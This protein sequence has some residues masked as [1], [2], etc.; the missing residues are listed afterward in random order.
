MVLPMDQ[1]QLPNRLALLIAIGGFMVASGCST[2][3]SIPEVGLDAPAVSTVAV[4]PVEE[5]RT[6]EPTPT[7]IADAIPAPTIEPEV[8]AAEEAE[9][10]STSTADSQSDPGPTAE[11]TPTSAFFEAL[12]RPLEERIAE[13]AAIEDVVIDPK[14]V[15]DRVSLDSTWWGLGADVYSGGATPAG[16][17]PDVGD[18]TV[19]CDD[20]YLDGSPQSSSRADRDWTAETAEYRR[21]EVR[22]AAMLDAADAANSMQRFQLLLEHCAG[23]VS[24]GA[25]MDVVDGQHARFLV[26]GGTDSD[27]VLVTTTFT[28]GSLVVHVSASGDASV[29]EQLIADAEY[30]LQAAVDAVE[31]ELE[32]LGAFAQLRPDLQEGLTRLD[33]FCRGHNQ[34]DTSIGLP[35]PPLEYFEGVVAYFDGVQS[36]EELGEQFEN[37]QSANAEM[38]EVVRLEPNLTDEELGEHP[39]WI[40]L[41]ERYGFTD[42]LTAVWEFGRENC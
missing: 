34:W 20:G 7:Q 32:R 33:D 37:F 14:R 10:E 28:A 17:I 29:V 18:P 27:I 19:F 24:A 4:E 1:I 35:R 22:A 6:P 9:P 40:E 3:A 41:R 16:P 31:D 11:P 26:L 25:T 15:A 12:N 30:G 36:P 42:A 8:S 39:I 38:L 5:T 21:V 2:T 13:L 23:A